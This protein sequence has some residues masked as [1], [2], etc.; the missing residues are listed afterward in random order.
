[1]TGRIQRVAGHLEFKECD[2]LIMATK[3]TGK[4]ASDADDVGI[5][6]R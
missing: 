4:K 5:G 1:M 3:A 6:R 2:R